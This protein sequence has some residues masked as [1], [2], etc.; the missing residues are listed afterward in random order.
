MYLRKVNLN[1]SPVLV[2]E[3]VWIINHF[4]TA[5]LHTPF[6]QGEWVFLPVQKNKFRIFRGSNDKNGDRVAYAISSLIPHTG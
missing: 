1:L 3:F 4:R 6:N 2:E 5:N